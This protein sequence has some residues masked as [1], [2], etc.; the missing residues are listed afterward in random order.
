MRQLGVRP[1]E[2]VPGARLGKELHADFYGKH[3]PAISWDGYAA[4]YL[5]EMGGAQQLWRIRDLARR[6]AAGEAITYRTA[7]TVKDI[8]VWAN[9][10]RDVGQL[11]TPVDPAKLVVD[12]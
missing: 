11:T 2:V 3:G 4:R 7:I 6:A 5:D 12:Q 10:L 8:D 9:V 1:A